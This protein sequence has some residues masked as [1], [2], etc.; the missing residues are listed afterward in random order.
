MGSDSYVDMF[1][2][3]FAWQTYDVI[4]SVLRD[5]GLCLLPF[6]FIV[7]KA[8][9][10]AATSVQPGKRGLVAY[11]Q[12]KIDILIAS[13]VFV[14]AMVP[15]S[16][17]TM[18]DSKSARVNLDC[19]AAGTAVG[20][21]TSG[22]T[23][24]TALDPSF[25]SLGGRTAEIPIWWGFIVNLSNS[26]TAA[27]VAGLP[28][29]TDFRTFQS[30][31][32][33]ER[34]RD[35]VVRQEVKEF[36]QECFYKAMHKY[37][38]DKPVGIKLEDVNWIGADYF[39]NTPGFY[40]AMQPVEPRRDVTYNSTRD[41]PG[42]PSAGGRPYCKD[43]YRS[44]YQKLKGN[45]EPDLFSKANLPAFGNWFPG[46][47][48]TADKE[49]ELVKT[50]VSLDGGGMFDGGNNMNYE[51]YTGGE[52]YSHGV[53]L[54]AGAGALGVRV[55]QFSHF[56]QMGVFRH[57]APIAQAFLTMAIVI[58]LPFLLIF[59]LYSPGPVATAS[60]GFF[61]AKFLTLLWG[62]AFW[63]DNAMFAALANSSSA[64][65]LTNYVPVDS[66]LTNITQMVTSTLYIGLPVVFLAV[67]G[68]A[69]VRVGSMVT[70]FTGKTTDAAK[71]AGGA[72]ADTAGQL[73]KAGI[74]RRLFPNGKGKGG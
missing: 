39:M 11:H 64:D 30:D 19:S 4:Y 60:V 70:D 66:A 43:W 7:L 29:S 68:W 15:F 54:S 42:N 1:A 17:M 72:V 56:A 71:N 67:M 8:F 41:G 69:G 28:C 63:I 9:K 52:G 5:T 22:S 14:L 55:S 23:T 58:S 38:S 57:A 51:S 10:S 25:T 62:V 73:V 34:V 2:T 53:D 24:G 6:I 26:V 49:R 33:Q 18:A 40:D 46:G 50:V 16:T 61:T 3:F 35:P 47:M 74:S 48:T 21:E 12:A 32:S 59:S 65:G 44:L 13:F 37:T 27:S 20:V 31:L 36:A 45:I